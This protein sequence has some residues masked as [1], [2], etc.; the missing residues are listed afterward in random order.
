MLEE[1]ILVLNASIQELIVR[2]DKG[3]LSKSN[4]P[5]EIVKTEET[6]IPAAPAKKATKKKAEPV[7]EETPAEVDPFD[8]SEPEEKEVKKVDEISTD[9]LAALAQKTIERIGSRDKVKDVIFSFNVSRIGELK[10][11][12]RL[13]C[14]DALL[15]LKS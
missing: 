3:L 8:F 9:D 4:L 13:L 2:V 15:A 7:V 12:T 10:D 5:E 11:A 1:A 6:V 14:R